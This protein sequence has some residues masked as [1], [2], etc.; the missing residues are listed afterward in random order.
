VTSNPRTRF[1]KEVID[2]VIAHSKTAKTR[3]PATEKVPSQVDGSSAT[4]PSPPMRS[5]ALQT[6]PKVGPEFERVFSKVIGSQVP[7]ASKPIDYSE[8]YQSAFGRTTLQKDTL[9]PKQ[10]RP[11]VDK[12]AAEG[13]PTLDSTAT[14]RRA[15][16]LSANYTTVFSRLAK[17][18]DQDGKGAEIRESLKRCV[19]SAEQKKVA[20]PPAK[21]IFER[22]SHPEPAVKDEDSG[23]TESSETTKDEEIKF[24]PSDSSAGPK[25]SVFERLSSSE[26]K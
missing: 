8:T 15:Q 7:P 1:P 11:Q 5:E 4:R 22:F 21:S 19:E 18:E 26:S 17:D 10:E 13:K 16:G 24:T 12:P 23:S 2:S 14:E 25:K 6:T 20:A 9:P 3:A